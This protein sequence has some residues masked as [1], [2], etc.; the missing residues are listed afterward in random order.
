[1]SMRTRP[2][3]DEE[4]IESARTSRERA[5]STARKSTDL[6]KQAAKLE[7]MVHK[8]E[9]HLRELKAVVRSAKKARFA[10]KA[11]LKT[12]QRRAG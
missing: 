7:E 3:T 12:R 5:A 11:R 4:V 9:A 1:M 2:R 10:K 6:L 8:T